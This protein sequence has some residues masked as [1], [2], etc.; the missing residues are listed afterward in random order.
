ME[1][2]KA[3]DKSNY[4]WVWVVRS[5]RTN[6]GE[7]VPMEKDDQLYICAM[8]ADS[9]RFHHRSKG[10]SEN[11]GLWN[12]ATG[13][14]DEKSNVISGKLP[15]GTS[16]EMILAREGDYHRITCTHV[17]NPPQGHWD[18]DDETGR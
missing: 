15:D 13:K 1:G 14:L 18:A 8:D 5:V 4:E 7:K 2:E 12:E 11:S 6:K 16:F 3:L 10:S 9:I 17:R